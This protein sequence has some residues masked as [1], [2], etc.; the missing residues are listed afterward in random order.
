M[1]IMKK[2][3]LKN[4]SAHFDR[5]PLVSS[6]VFFTS[7]A[8]ALGAHLYELYRDTV[9]FSYTED[10]AITHVCCD[11]ARLF[12]L[13]RLILDCSGGSKPTRV[14]LSLDE[15]GVASLSICMQ[16]VQELPQRDLRV[17]AMLGHL[18]LYENDD[19]VYIQMETRREQ[20]LHLFALDPDTL[21]HIFQRVDA[22]IDEIPYEDLP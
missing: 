8:E 5:M 19:G 1:T 2:R 3:K 14:H 4:V 15:D 7:L 22:I 20:V 10:R 17:I 11:V 9:D 12:V 6:S 13:V 18:R 21:L 16:R